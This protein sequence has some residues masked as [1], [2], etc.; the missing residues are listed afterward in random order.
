MAGSSKGRNGQTKGG[1]SFQ[2]PWLVRRKLLTY[3]GDLDGVS[4]SS[5]SS[6]AWLLSL[7]TLLDVYS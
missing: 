6:A 1:Q 4:G 5:G 2:G 7:K 3:E